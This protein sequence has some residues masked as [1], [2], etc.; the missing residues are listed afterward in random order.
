MGVHYLFSTLTHV[1]E[2]FHNE[3]IKNITIKTL[4]S[5]VFT[6]ILRDITSGNFLLQKTTFHVQSAYNW[7]F[8]Q[9]VQTMYQN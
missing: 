6:L 7:Q 5:L 8:F 1:F 9:V 2:I 4:I 3:E